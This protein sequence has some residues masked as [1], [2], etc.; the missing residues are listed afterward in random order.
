MRLNDILK[1][2][3]HAFAVV[4]AMTL[5]GVA[6]ELPAAEGVSGTAGSASPPPPVFAEDADLLPPPPPPHRPQSQRPADGGGDCGRMP[7]QIYEYFQRLKADNPA[8][9]QR[10]KELRSTDSEQFRRELGRLFLAQRHNRLRGR[11][12]HYDDGCWALARQLRS[13]PPP[14]NAAEL[15]ARLK[16]QIALSFET[17]VDHIRQRLE[18]LQKH[19]DNIQQSRE[20]ILSDRLE[21]FL[22]APLPPVSPDG[23]GGGVPPSGGT[24]R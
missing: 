22:N 16:E 5:A 23:Q 8:E 19:L 4:L 1:T 13:D 18:A 14:A 12:R 9:Y 20:R 10:L 11:L 17:M 24:Q 6:M 15:E 3:R 2:V 7:P 21:F